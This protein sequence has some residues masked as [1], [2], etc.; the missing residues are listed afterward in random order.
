MGEVMM[1]RSNDLY[2]IPL[3]LGDAVA[4]KSVN[5]LLRFAGEKAALKRV[6]A[7]IGGAEKKIMVDTGPPDP[8][9][10][11]RYHA[12]SKA[13]P[14]RPEQSLE[15]QLAKAGVTP[16]EID[17]VVLTHLHWDHVGEVTRFPKA[18]FIV[19]EE[20]LSFAFNPLPPQYVAYEALQIGMEP[21]FLKV[22]ERIKTVSMKEK[23][24]VEGVRVIPLP[25]HTPGS[26]GVVVDTEKGPHVIAGD[27]VPQYGNLEGAP[28][29][30]LPYLV[31]SIFT[32]MRAMWKSFERIDEIVGG[33]LTRVIPGHDPRI[34]Q[35][36]RYP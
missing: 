30:G 18:E 16:E 7:Y 20:E 35:K 27:A 22:M 29:E 11:A 1:E 28:E 25:G 9:R 14:P 23:E 33:D 12:L 3:D 34:F 32:D 36:Q 6:A 2:I 10:T 8:E 21:I 13:E 24:I 15:A 5:F 31:S 26:I 4:D 19:S 17:I